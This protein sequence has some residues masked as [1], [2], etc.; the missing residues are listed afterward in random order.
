MAADDL[1]VGFQGVLAPKLAQ[2]LHV[3]DDNT[4][5]A[6]CG[7]GILFWSFR[8]GEQ[9]HFAN[10]EG[11]DGVACFC[12]NRR[13]GVFAFSPRHTPPRIH[14]HEAAPPRNRITQTDEGASLEYGSL[15]LSWNAQ[16]VLATAS[17]A[18]QKVRAGQMPKAPRVIESTSGSTSRSRAL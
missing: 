17:I 15:A 14:V 1:Q 7:N 6:V 18:E 16:W 13:K 11:V 12:F 8:T 5:A 3:V 10:P 9:D 2:Q 4:I